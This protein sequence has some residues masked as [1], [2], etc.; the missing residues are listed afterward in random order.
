MLTLIEL[1]PRMFSIICDTEI[2]SKFI[3]LSSTVEKSL[4]QAPK[5]ADNDTPQ[6]L[7]KFDFLTHHGIDNASIVTVKL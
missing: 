4:R 7:T 6:M 5:R 3:F 2:K 1:L